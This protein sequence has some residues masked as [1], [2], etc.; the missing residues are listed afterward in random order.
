VPAKLSCEAERGAQVLSHE[1]LLGREV[2]ETKDRLKVQ[3]NGGIIR[4]EVSVKG[5]S[6]CSECSKNCLELS[7]LDCKTLVETRK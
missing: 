2:K 1:I 7:W 4:L 6:K 3:T 5:K